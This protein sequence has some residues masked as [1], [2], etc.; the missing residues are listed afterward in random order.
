M[1]AISG[2]SERV[3]RTNAENREERLALNAARDKQAIGSLRRI[4]EH[5]PFCARPGDGQIVGY[6]EKRGWVTVRVVANPAGTFSS[7]ARDRIEVSLTRAGHEALA[8]SREE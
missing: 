8:A 6:L 2:Y 5:D 3:E 1:T 7:A 4:S